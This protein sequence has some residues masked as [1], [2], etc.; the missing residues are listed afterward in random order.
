VHPSTFDIRVLL[1]AV[2]TVLGN[3]PL[4]LDKTLGQLLAST[5][6]AKLL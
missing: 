1:T 6:F 5:D 2:R 3:K 4:P